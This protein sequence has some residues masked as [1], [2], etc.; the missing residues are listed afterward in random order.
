MKRKKAK[1]HPHAPKHPKSAYLYFAQDNRDKLKEAFPGKGFTEI[2]KILGQQWRSLDPE[3]RKRYT[4]RAELDKVRYK[5]E[6]D[7]FEPPTQVEEDLDM[8]PKK[9]VKRKKHPLAPKHPLSSYLFFV[10]VNRPKMNVEHPEKGF[11]EVAQILGSTWKGLPAHE[12]RKYDILAYADK[13]RYEEEKANWVPPVEK[14]TGKKK[15]RK[16]PTTAKKDEDLTAFQNWAVHERNLVLHE[17]PMID[18]KEL[19]RILKSKWKT[20][21]PE[22]RELYSL[23]QSFSSAVPPPPMYDMLQPYPPQEIPAPPAPMPPNKSRGR[24]RK[25]EASAEVLNWNSHE[26]AR[27]I[28]SL[29]LA[30]HRESFLMSGITGAEFIKLTSPQLRDNFHI[31]NI[32]DRKK[33]IKGIQ[34]L[35][36]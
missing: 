6:K 10:A 26:V 15:K 27:F 5:E 31:A 20:L 29:G 16:T 2:A 11:T 3:T 1:K 32:G 7:R 18:K 8:E 30:E 22:L 13:K 4:E 28:A 33:I 24:P 34:N 25:Y 23:N 36:K 21:P 19:E 14:E 9:K 12:R 35:I 17:N